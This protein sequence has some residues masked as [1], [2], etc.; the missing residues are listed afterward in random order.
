MQEDLFCEELA[1]PDILLLKNL[2]LEYAST[3][4]DLCNNLAWESKKSVFFGKE[5]DIPRQILWFGDIPYSYS[6]ISHPPCPFPDFLLS[7]KKELEVECSNSLGRIVTFNSVLL[8]K[9]RSGMDSIGYHADDEKF[10]DKEPVIASVSLGSPRTF[11]FKNK[12]DSK[13]KQK[14]LLTH[15]SKLVM[16]GKT[17]IDWYHGIPKEPSILTPRINLTFRLTHPSPQC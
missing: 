6:G 5:Y 9:Y 12:T 4:F 3:L 17:Q 15:G 14:H 11:I 7:L 13:I 16:F 10:L 1:S 2:D 8:N